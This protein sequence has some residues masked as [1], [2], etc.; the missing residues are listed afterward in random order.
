MTSPGRASGFFAA[1]ICA[2]ILTCAAPAPAAVLCVSASGKVPAGPAKKLGCGATVF[3]KIGDAVAAALTGDSV[4]VFP[5]SYDE[6]VTIDKSGLQLLGQ[7]AKK[8]IIDATGQTNGV[9]DSAS[10]VTISGFTIE[11]ANH[12]GILVSGA[13]ATCNGDTPPE[14]HPVGNPPSKVTIANNIVTDNDKGL[15]AGPPPSCAGAPDFEAEDCGEAIH[16]DGVTFSTVANNVVK[17]N[18]GG[19]LLTDETNENLGNLVN[20]NDVEDNTPDCGIT[21]PSHPPNGSGA[22]IGSQSFGVSNNTIANNISKGNGAAGVGMFTPT[23][24]TASQ[25][26]LVIGNTI[27]NNGEPGVLFHSHA[28]HQKLSNNSIISNTIS[29]NGADPNPGPTESDGPVAPTGIEVYA[30]VAADPVPVD[31]AGNT[32]SGES[33]DIWIG[34]PGWNN[35]SD[36]AP[37]YGTLVHL[38]NLLGKSA[39]GVNNTGNAGAVFAIAPQN[40]WGCGKGPGQKGCSSAAGNVTT[41]PFLSKT[42]RLP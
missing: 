16:L 3:S 4:A 34:A 18:A 35:C 36:T 23:P 30:D 8:T 2:A 7:N 5:G 38:N 25:K 12:E 10:G 13:A 28:P 27:A 22:N 39:T 31:I 9:L 1:A 32:I 21:L 17:S 14:C 42:A 24:G 15:V 6:M 20:A 37:C 29:G 41:N 26:N 11:N 40:F 33:N 19:I